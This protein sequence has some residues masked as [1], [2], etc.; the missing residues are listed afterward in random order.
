ML[1]RVLVFELFDGRVVLDTYFLGEAGQNLIKVLN[2][3]PV[4]ADGLFDFVDALRDAA[5]PTVRNRARAMG[6]PVDD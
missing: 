6:T 5:F 3:V 2:D 1:H 4:G